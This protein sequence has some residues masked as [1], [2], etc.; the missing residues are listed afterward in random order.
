MKGRGKR[1][2]PEKT[3]RPAASSV[4]IPSCEHLGATAPGIESRWPRWEASSL[5]ILEHRSSR[6]FP[7]CSVGRRCSQFGHGPRILGSN[8]LLT[9]EPLLWRINLLQAVCYIQM[10]SSLLGRA[11]PFSVWPRATYSW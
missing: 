6:W 11:S 8:G 3:R 5:Q 10:V 9:K 4:T 2:I 1:E 7:A